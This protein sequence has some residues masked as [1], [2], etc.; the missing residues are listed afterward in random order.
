MVVKRP[1]EQRRKLPPELEAF[2][3]SDEEKLRIR[4]PRTDRG[5]V[6]DPR[7]GYT[8]A[9]VSNRDARTVY[10]VRASAMRACL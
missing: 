4:R 9:G 10:D 2:A 1:P 6:K 5:Q 7:E 8:V 3:R